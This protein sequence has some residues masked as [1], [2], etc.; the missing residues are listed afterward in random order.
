MGCDLGEGGK[1]LVSGLLSETDVSLPT[2]IPST[3]WYFTNSLLHE[4]HVFYFGFLTVNLCV[5]SHKCM[6]CIE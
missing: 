5:L 2:T 4:K 1:T 3:V 6:M